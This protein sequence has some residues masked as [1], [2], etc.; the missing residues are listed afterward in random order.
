EEPSAARLNAAVTTGSGFLSSFLGRGPTA[1]KVMNAGASAAR[2]ANRA[3]KQAKEVARD[4]EDLAELLSKHLELQR[5]A[6]QAVSEI[7]STNDAATLPLE[8]VVTKPKKTG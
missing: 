5:E 8:T 2:S 6:Q 4:K 7:A 1:R 3:A